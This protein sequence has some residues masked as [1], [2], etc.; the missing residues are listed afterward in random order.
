MNTREPNHIKKI[1]CLCKLVACVNIKNLAIY[2]TMPH[3][4]S[5]QNYKELLLFYFHCNHCLEK[6]KIV[7][8]NFTPTS[9]PF[10]HPHVSF[11]I[12]SLPLFPSF[13]RLDNLCVCEP[14]LK[15][16]GKSRD[17]IESTPWGL[18]FVF[19]GDKRT[20]TECL[21][22]PGSCDTEEG[23][24]SHEKAPNKTGGGLK[25]DNDLRNWL[26]QLWR[27]W[28]EKGYKT[29]QNVLKLFWVQLI[30]MILN[31]H[32]YNAKNS[33]GQLY[34]VPLDMSLAMF[35]NDTFN[36][37]CFFCLYQK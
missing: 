3:I 14:E 29:A 1:G 33:A 8:N 27:K 15:S 11:P 25:R 24:R 28:K 18:F 19:F 13:W 32:L 16:W 2:K 21:V 23:G 31:L 30:A 34:M 9:H 36:N 20:R 10:P 4:Q 35:L 22:S 7:L 6:K 37:V 17:V 26:M 12:P 5:V